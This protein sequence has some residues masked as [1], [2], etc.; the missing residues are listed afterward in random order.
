MMGKKIVLATGIF[1]PDIGG[2]ATYSQLIFDKL[3]E[4]G[5]TVKTLAYGERRKSDSQN[6]IRISRKLPW[7]W[8]HLIYFFRAWSLAKEHDLIFIQGAVSEGLPAMLAAKLAGKR[9]VLKIVGDYAWEQGIQR[10]RVNDSIEDFQ[11]R[12]YGLRVALL[13]RTQIW[14]AKSAD[15]I[16]VPSAYLKKIV[17]NWGVEEYKIK[18]IYNSSNL[19]FVDKIS[20][21]DNSPLVV[22]SVGRLVPWKGFGG[23]LEVFQRLLNKKFH[24]KLWIIGDGPEFYRLKAMSEK[25]KVADNVLFLGKLSPAELLEKFKLADIFALNSFYEGFSH[26]VLEAM[27]SVLPVVVSNAGGNQEVVRNRQDGF[28]FEAGNLNE[29]ER[30]LE[31]LILDKEQRLSMA[32]KAFARAHYFTQEKMLKELS[33]FLESI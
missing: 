32:E 11:S 17:T 29:L 21:R 16:I 1:P 15:F 10:F 23:L 20:V 18:V 6:I 3:P 28:L 30:Q 22:V 5:F 8:R 12:K 31:I 19:R 27:A 9:T 14:V 13:K 4:Y 33:S 7:A 2:P 26:A 24:L 25:L